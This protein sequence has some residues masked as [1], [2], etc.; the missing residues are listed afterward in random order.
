MFS[1]D[2]GIDLGTVN[3]LIYVK[4]EG[5]VLNEPS[6]IVIDE[7]TKNIIAVGEEANSMLGKTP[8]KLKVIRPMKD[9]V[10]A[11]FDMVEA[12]LNHFLRRI[13]QGNKISKPRILICC[14]SN[15]TEVEKNAI[16]EVAEKTGAKKFL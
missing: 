5:I 11:N 9:G 13:K 15:I 14:P 2:I 16:K 7:D 3:V 1:K 4:G 6:V 12:L 10:I 8:G